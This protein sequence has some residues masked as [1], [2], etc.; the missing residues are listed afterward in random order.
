MMLV[1]DEHLMP[2]HIAK[3]CGLHFSKATM[4]SLSYNVTFA[5]LRHHFGILARGLCW[6]SGLVAAG[7]HKAGASVDIH[8]IG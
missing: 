8:K 6:G 1:Q 7:S 5:K 2:S 4:A 3:E